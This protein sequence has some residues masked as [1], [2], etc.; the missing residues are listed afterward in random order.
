[1]DEHLLG[2]RPVERLR[3]KLPPGTHKDVT[4]YPAEVSNSKRTARQLDEQRAAARKAMMART[5]PLSV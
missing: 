4:G 3:F 5:R 2:D 1:M